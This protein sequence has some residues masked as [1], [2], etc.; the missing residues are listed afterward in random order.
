MAAPVQLIHVFKSYVDPPVYIVD[1]FSLSINENEFFCLV[2]PSGCGKSTVLKLIAGILTPTKG[3][4]V[5]PAR[6][7]MVFQS[8]ALLPWLTV[9]GNIEFAARMQGFDSDKVDAVTQRY[10]KM[11]HLEG[12]AARYPRELSGGQRQRVGIARALAIE[13][14]V[15]LLDEPFSALDPVIVDELH[16]NLLEI[17]KATNKTIIMISHHFE[18]AVLLADRIGVMCDGALKEIIDVS[19]PRPRTEE[20]AP[21]MLEVKKLRSCL[22]PAP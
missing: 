1:D 9:Q 17:W 22:T 20:Q 10:L 11:V 3:E 7:G 15:L 6:V 12:Y 16:Q 2:G 5:R 14:E 13:E 18:E 21:F 19:L 4:L 8:Y